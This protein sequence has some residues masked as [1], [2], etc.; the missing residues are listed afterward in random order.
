MIILP[1]HFK[2]MNYLIFSVFTSPQ[3]TRDNLRHHSNHWGQWAESTSPHRTL[4]PHGLASRPITNPTSSGGRCPLNAQQLRCAQGE[5]DERWHHH[6]AIQWALGPLKVC[7]QR[8]PEASGSSS[9]G[10]GGGA[11]G[12]GRRRAGRREADGGG[13]VHEWWGHPRKE[14][15]DGW[16]HQRVGWLVLNMLASS[17]VMRWLIASSSFEALINYNN[18]SNWKV[19]LLDCTLCFSRLIFMPETSSPLC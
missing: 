3:Y 17:D 18:N 8:P 13:R 4:L 7:V 19:W 14:R 6:R 9:R 1:L 10:E 15:P 5:H 16:D 2:R 11:G 12:E